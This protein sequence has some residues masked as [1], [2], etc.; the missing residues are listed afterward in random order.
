VLGVGYQASGGSARESA[1]SVRQSE[2]EVN[3]SDV[4]FEA[5]RV[6]KRFGDQIVLEGI[7]LK[8]RRGTLS[9]IMG[10]NG[11]GKSTCFNVLTGYYKPDSG[12]I[13]YD[14]REIGG[15]SPGAISKL[16]IARSFQVMTLFAEFSA[17]ENIL[18]ALRKTVDSG[19]N[20]YRDLRAD[21][22][23]VDRAAA[24]LAEVGLRG[25]EK[26]QVRAM[27]YGEQ[28]ALE[29]GVALAS[30]PKLLF[31]DEPT[32]GLGSD[33]RRNL[34]GLIERLKE[35]HT[36]V[37]IEHDIPFLF[38]LADEVN[39]IHWGQVIAQGTPASLAQSKW[40]RAAMEAA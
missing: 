39:V 13:R 16:G 22:V 15:L 27:P 25:R 21:S 34:L 29:I 4:L 9:G 19:F 30:E 3:S 20:A 26:T 32:Q 40:V 7:S 38:R 6:R 33:G 28:R 24:I 35:S 5:D 1:R 8:F 17:L 37:M 2:V 11:A 12:Q 23:S 10:P 36:L 14:G 18:V 31:L